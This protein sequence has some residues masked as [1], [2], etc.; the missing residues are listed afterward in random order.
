MVT[1]EQMTAAFTAGPSADWIQLGEA[2]TPWHDGGLASTATG[3]SAGGWSVDA[4]L[5]LDSAGWERVFIDRQFSTEYIHRLHDLVSLWLTDDD[6]RRLRHLVSAGLNS[7][8]IA[9]LLSGWLSGNDVQRLGHLA[10]GM[11]FEDKRY[12]VCYAVYSAKRA[13]QAAW[14]R[15]YGEP[16]FSD[17]E[18][19]AML[20]SAAADDDDDVALA[21]TGLDDDIALWPA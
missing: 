1:L 10:V 15:V 18:I 9:G 4:L 6:Y 20:D 13:A 5:S 14:E 17:A 2:F 12:P 7:Q 8:D 16:G 19:T 3:Y 11:G 21:A